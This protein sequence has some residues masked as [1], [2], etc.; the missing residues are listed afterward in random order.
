MPN[1]SRKRLSLQD[2]PIFPVDE[3]EEAI[4]YLT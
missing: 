2:D 4:N 1:I 3:L